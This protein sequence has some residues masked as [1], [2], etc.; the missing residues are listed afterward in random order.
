M[1]TVTNNKTHLLNEHAVAEVL[2]VSVAT[3]RRWRSLEQGPRF[4]KVGFAV[5]YRNED[6]AA[7]LESR[8]TG[9][10]PTTRSR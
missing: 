9:G 6:V 4:I 7:W 10:E 8:P 1:G 3:I 2:G 5:R